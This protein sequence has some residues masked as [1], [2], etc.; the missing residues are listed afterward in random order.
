MKRGL[1]LGLLAALALLSGCHDAK[2][3]RMISVPPPAKVGSLDQH[4]IRLS[5]GV[6]LGIE[7]IDPESK[8]ART[9][10]RLHGR[11]NDP[12]V[13]RAFAADTDQLASAWAPG[14]TSRLTE[15]RSV[16]VVTGLAAG[17]T[18]VQIQTSGSLEDFD[19]EVV[20]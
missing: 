11:S 12:A 10:G 3:F 5:K 2:E 9:C 6:A 20:E 15:R 14:R 19:V 8:A 7:C 18:H 17:R 1:S 4:T 13:A 16:F